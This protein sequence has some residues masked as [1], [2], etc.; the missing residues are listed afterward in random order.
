MTETWI[1][2]IVT[3]EQQRAQAEELHAKAERDKAAREKL[4][5]KWP[6]AVA[7][8]RAHLRFVRDVLVKLQPHMNRPIGEEARR[9][10]ST[11]PA[12]D[13]FDSREHGWLVLSEAGRILLG[14]RMSALLSDADEEPIAT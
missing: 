7:N 5:E 3:D 11:L 12:N 14:P 4:F 9:L 13:Y 6:L 2:S 1:E 10:L 8:Q